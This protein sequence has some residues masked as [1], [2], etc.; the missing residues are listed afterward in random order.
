MVGI[1]SV[2]YVCANVHLTHVYL[3]LRECSFIYSIANVHM[4]P[5]AH[6]NTVQLNQ[7]HSMY[8]YA[9]VHMCVCTHVGQLFMHTVSDNTVYVHR[10]HFGLLSNLLMC[11]SNCV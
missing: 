1:K 2:T 4:C 10:Q 7:V 9:H 11:G 8:Y 6:V 3:R 5:T